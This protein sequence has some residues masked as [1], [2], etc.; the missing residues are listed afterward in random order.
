MYFFFGTL[1]LQFQ[2][3]QFDSEQP[4][5]IAVITKNDIPVSAFGK[6]IE[7][8][9]KFGALKFCH[10]ASVSL[11]VIYNCEITAAKLEHKIQYTDSIFENTPFQSATFPKMATIS[12]W[13]KKIQLDDGC[14]VRNLIL[15]TSPLHC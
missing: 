7:N 6:A 8:C 14:T 1:K 4:S 2:N 10:I 13:S 12:V 5:K 9:Q 15:T 3:F 11:I